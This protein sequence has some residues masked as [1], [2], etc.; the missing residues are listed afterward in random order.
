MLNILIGIIIAHV[1]AVLVFIFFIVLF[2]RTRNDQL[3]TLQIEDGEKDLTTNEKPQ[4][5]KQDPANKRKHRKYINECNEQQRSDGNL[6]QFIN[7]GP[8]RFPAEP[9]DKAFEKKCTYPENVLITKVKYEPELNEVVPIGSD[10]DMIMD[11][12]KGKSTQNA[13]QKST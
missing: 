11:G 7:T 13:V 9:D 6:K 4:F 10:V 8:I 2:R 5:N 1:I 3:D 12:N